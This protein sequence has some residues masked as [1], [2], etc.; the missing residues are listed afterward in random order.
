[1][2]NNARPDEMKYF[3]IIL[4]AR[5]RINAT[6]VETR[7]FFTTLSGE[8]VKRSDRRTTFGGSFYNDNTLRERNVSALLLSQTHR[9]HD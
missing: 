9:V 3:T 4:R 1:M 6:R 7:S 5:A 8:L 2:E